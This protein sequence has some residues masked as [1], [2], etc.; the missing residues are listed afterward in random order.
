M[1]NKYLK[2]IDFNKTTLIH[3]LR[4]IIGCIFVYASFD[5]IV[6]PLKFSNVISSFEFSSLIGLSSLDNILALSLPFLEIMLGIC[7]IFG[8]FINEVINMLVM[9][10]LFFIIILSQAYFRGIV[11]SDCGCGL[12][13]SSIGFD[14]LRDFIL[15]FICLLIKFRKLILRPIYER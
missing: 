15:L 9:L 13:E 4:F 1:I 6:D 3:Y 14:I 12:N 7:L 2:K 8:I 11:L 10:L 5:K